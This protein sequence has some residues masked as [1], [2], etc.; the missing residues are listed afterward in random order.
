MWIPF[1]EWMNRLQPDHQND[2]MLLTG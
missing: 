2:F 1:S